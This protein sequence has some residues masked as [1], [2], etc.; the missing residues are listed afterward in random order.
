MK[1]EEFLKTKDN[2]TNEEIIIILEVLKNYEDCL[3]ETIEELLSDIRDCNSEELEELN[4]TFDKFMKNKKVIRKTI[5]VLDS[6]RFKNMG[7]IK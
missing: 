5:F 7:V 2:F 6:Y 3:S 4:N 1:L